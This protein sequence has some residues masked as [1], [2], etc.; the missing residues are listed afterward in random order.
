MGRVA[1]GI[2]GKNKSQRED[3]KADELETEEKIRVQ[4]DG[5]M[6]GNGDGSN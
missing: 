4:S 2:A 3:I 5:R 6:C 1:R